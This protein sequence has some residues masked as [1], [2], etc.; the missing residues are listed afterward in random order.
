MDGGCYEVRERQRLRGSVS[1]PR[2]GG[3]CVERV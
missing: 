3:V 2:M 1:D